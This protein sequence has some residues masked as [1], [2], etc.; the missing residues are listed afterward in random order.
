MTEPEL[1]PAQAEAVRRLLADARHDGPM[2]EDVAVRLEGFVAGLAAE[3]AA[4]RAAESETGTVLPLRRR[5]WAQALV[6]AAAVAAVGVGLTQVI[7]GD[8]SADDSGGG[9]AAGGFAQGASEDAG[10]DDGRADGVR[11]PVPSA[12]TMTG[13][14]R[15][16]SDYAAAN[17]ALVDGLELSGLQSLDPDRLSVS[18]RSLDRPAQALAPETA[19]KATNSYFAYSHRGR[20]L[21]RTCGPVYTVQ[22]GRYTYARYHHRFALVLYHPA[23]HGAQLVEVYV[24]ASATPRKS[25]ARVT[26]W[27][28]E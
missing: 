3:R 23:I 18:L 26:L 16:G 5:R 25:V 15:N 24:C 27:D 11:V 1:T 20:L 17:G 22:D 13:T 21:R 6:A 4:E 9:S 2:P 12:P 28:G 10:A 8:Q 14:H 19:T 7:G